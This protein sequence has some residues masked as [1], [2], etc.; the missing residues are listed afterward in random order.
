MKKIFLF[1]I[2]VLNLNAKNLSID[3]DFAHFKY[4]ENKVAW[5]LYYA[6]P[7]T[8]LT[9]K[10]NGSKYDGEL[11][12]D[13]L[14]VENDK[15]VILDKFKIPS[16]FDKEPNKHQINIYGTRT[17]EIDPGEYKCFFKI[18]DN[19]SK[20]SADI[21]FK[22]NIQGFD[23]RNIDISDLQLAKLISGKDTSKILWDKMF[24][25]NNLYVIPNPNKI[26]DIEPFDLKLYYEIYN[27]GKYAED[28]FL[29][30]Y[31]VYDGA[32]RKIFTIPTKQKSYS[33]IIVKSF[34]QP[35][36]MI[37]TGTYFIE[38]EVKYPIDNP[39]VSVKK[40]EKFFLLNKYLAPQLT[41]RFTESATFE[42]SQ[43][44]SMGLDEITSEFRQLKFIATKAEIDAFELLTSLRAKQRYIFRFWKN[45]DIDTNDR[46]NIARRDFMESVDFANRYFSYGL[47]KEG[48]NTDRGRILLKYGQPDERDIHVSDG[49]LNAYEEWFY[50]DVE[51]GGS[52]VF[53]DKQGFNDFI[54]VHSTA[55]GEIKDYDWYN[56]HVKRFN[57]NNEPED[58]DIFQG[59]YDDS[60]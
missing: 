44:A 15:T 58:S 31:N 28:G 10:N 46:I 17:Y 21:K 34:T 40:R 23:D 35:M 1:L 49:D 20:D 7:D 54:L 38:V 19:V 16:S 45:R 57:M 30:D 6:F 2:I 8:M 48:W 5:E 18:Y 59:E 36:S 60:Y 47:N 51:G 13:F 25:K 53:V 9:Y 56:N 24:L 55:F 29:I 4:K 32:N 27:A 3:I 42:K 33:N 52:F 43:F 14:V 11:L 22:I 41:T 50:N 12:V 39:T 26:I 37:P